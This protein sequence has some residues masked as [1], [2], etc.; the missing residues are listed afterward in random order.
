MKLKQCRICQRQVPWL[1]THLE[2]PADQVV[3]SMIER[4]LPERT[5]EDGIC[6]PCLDRYKQSK[7]G[8]CF[9]IRITCN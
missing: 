1:V 3:I 7:I 5:G 4:N 8:G 6:L 9:E 2:E